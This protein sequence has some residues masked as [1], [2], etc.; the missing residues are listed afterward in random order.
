MYEAFVAECKKIYSADKV[1]SGIFGSTCEIALINDVSVI[2]SSYDQT[3]FGGPGGGKREQSLGASGSDVATHMGD[4]G[5]LEEMP[6]SRDRR[7]SPLTPAKA[8]DRPRRPEHRPLLT[9]RSKSERLRKPK[10]QKPP[11]KLNS[12]RRMKPMG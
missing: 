12:M 9:I 7:L 4:I 8:Q 5:I 10:Q 6:T 2:F 1:Q 11:E 3:L